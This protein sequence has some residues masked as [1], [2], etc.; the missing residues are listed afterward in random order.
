MNGAVQSLEFTIIILRN[1]PETQSR[2][3]KNVL[4]EDEKIK[5]IIKTFV[6]VRLTF[7]R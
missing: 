2:Q 7:F 6:S 1:I 3:S 5:R 4:L